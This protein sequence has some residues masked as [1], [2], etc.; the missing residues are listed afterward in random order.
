[1]TKTA[2]IQP[3]RNFI[4]HKHLTAEQKARECVYF[5]NAGYTVEEIAE[6][7]GI[8]KARVYM[9]IKRGGAIQQSSQNSNLH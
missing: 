2:P 1:M 3:Y 6:Y 7:F 5:K 9:L 4:R 8:S